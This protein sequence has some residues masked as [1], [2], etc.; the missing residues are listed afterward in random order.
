MYVLYIAGTLLEPGIGTPRFLGIYFVSLLA[1][2]FGA[3]LLSPHDLTVGASGAIFGLMA[4]VIVVARGRG[5]EEVAS[6]FGLFIVLNLVLTFVD[7]RHLDRRPPRRPDRR[8]PRRGL[9][10]WSSA[11][12]PGRQGFALELGGIVLMIAATFA[13]ASRSRGGLAAVAA[14]AAA[15]AE[16]VRRP[17][18]HRR[19]RGS[20]RLSVRAT[21]RPAPTAPSATPTPGPDGA[22]R[23][24][25][26]HRRARPA[27][28]AGSLVGRADVARDPV[29]RGGC[30]SAP[31]ST[32][33][34]GGSASAPRAG[35]R[36][37][38][39]ARPSAQ[40]ALAPSLAAARR[41]ASRFR[42]STDA[43][44]GLLV[45]AARDRARERDRRPRAPNL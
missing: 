2:S 41:S 4:A 15:V 36:R 10:S 28:S 40:E 11:E 6:Q 32:G 14:A 43:F 9:V 22:A 18:L 42:S 17:R 30:R 45:G 7:P 12:L 3:L 5:I 13:G 37:P 25:P 20:G 1:G 26:A 34:L 31:S 16:L 39:P 19:R 29:A 38:K 44:S 8:R 23:D 35:R 24:A 33:R 21:P 27:S